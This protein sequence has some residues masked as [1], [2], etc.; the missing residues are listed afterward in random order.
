LRNT[1]RPAMSFPMATSSG[2]VAVLASGD[3]MMSPRLTSWR[4]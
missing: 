1:E 2:C 4:V 3:A